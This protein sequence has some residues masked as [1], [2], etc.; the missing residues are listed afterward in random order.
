ML[1]QR[2]PK[3]GPDPT[4]DELSKMSLKELLTYCDEL[5]YR[6]TSQ[7]SRLGTTLYFIGNA[8]R[9]LEAKNEAKKRHKKL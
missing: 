2:K 5:S 8:T 1:K 9:A 3:K 7:V 6:L 4:P